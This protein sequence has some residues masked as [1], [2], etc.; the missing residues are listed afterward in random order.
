MLDGFQP[1]MFYGSRHAVLGTLLVLVFVFTMSL[2][3]LNV[4]RFAEPTEPAVGASGTPVAHLPASVGMLTY[5]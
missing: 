4:V 2:V 1:D 5:S 3:L